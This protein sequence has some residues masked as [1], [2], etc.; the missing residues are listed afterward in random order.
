MLNVS[1]WRSYP[2]QRQQST[3][4]LTLQDAFLCCTYV[5]D[6]LHTQTQESP[7]ESCRYFLHTAPR[8]NEEISF[9]CAYEWAAFCFLDWPYPL[10]PGITFNMK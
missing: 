3:E 4:V 10:C 5:L 1:P 8:Q 2:L 7:E 9:L 6:S